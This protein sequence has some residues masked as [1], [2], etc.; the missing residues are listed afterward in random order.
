[1]VA[2]PGAP[3]QTAAVFWTVAVISDGDV[4]IKLDAVAVQPR[5]SVTVT[6]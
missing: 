3:P 1:M 5:L 4:K 2:E 6:A